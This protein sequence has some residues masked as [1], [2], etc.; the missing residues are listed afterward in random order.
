MYLISLIDGL[1]LTHSLPEYRN[2]LFKTMDICLASIQLRMG[3][4]EYLLFFQKDRIAAARSQRWKLVVE[5]Y[6][7]SVRARIGAATYHHP[8]GLLFDLENDPAERY[9]FTREQPELA[10]TMRRWIDDAYLE[11]VGGDLEDLP[12]WAQ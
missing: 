7:R 2:S 12:V 4:N 5:S 11:L 8:P 9:S 6:Y 10:R 1:K 3:G